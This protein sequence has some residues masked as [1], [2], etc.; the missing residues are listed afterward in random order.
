MSFLV[1]ERNN[2]IANVRRVWPLQPT[3][4]PVV[5]AKSVNVVLSKS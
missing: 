4:L 1:R 2:K 5:S 3:P